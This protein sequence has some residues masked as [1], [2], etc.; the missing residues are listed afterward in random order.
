MP[1]EVELQAKLE[2][3]KALAIFYHKWFR[4]CHD[5]VKYCRDHGDTKRAEQYLIDS[6]K[7]FD[8]IINNWDAI[9]F[10]SIKDNAFIYDSCLPKEFRGYK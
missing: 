8:I 5:S 1:N 3:R 6:E 4:D 2:F 9:E 7:Y 10:F